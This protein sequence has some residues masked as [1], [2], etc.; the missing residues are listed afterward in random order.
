MYVK[1]LLTGLACLAYIQFVTPVPHVAALTEEAPPDVLVPVADEGVEHSQQV[2]TVMT[3]TQ[4]NAVPANDMVTPSQETTAEQFQ[5]SQPIPSVQTVTKSTADQAPSLSV[6][7]PLPAPEGP[8]YVSMFEF[9]QTKGFRFVEIWNTSSEHVKLDNI[10]ITLEYYDTDSSDDALPYVCQLPLTGYIAPKSHVTYAQPELVTRSNGAYPLHDCISSGRVLVDAT[11]TVSVLGQLNGIDE[12][13]LIPAVSFAEGDRYIRKTTAKTG[14]LTADFT[15]KS[16]T[17]TIAGE[18]PRTSQVYLPPS[19]LPLQVTEIFPNPLLCASGDH[20]ARC[21][22]YIKVVNVS[23][24][25]VDLARYRLRNGSPQAK[26]S[27][28]N[29]STLTG[30]V[31]PHDFTII[32]VDAN[33]ESLAINDDAGATWFEDMLGMVTYANTDAPYEKASLAANQGYAWAYDPSDATW[34]WTVPSPDVKETVFLEPGKGSG[35]IVEGST[36]APCPTGQYRAIETNRCRMIAVATSEQAP[37]KDGQ[38]RSEQTNRCR[39]VATSSD[40]L[41][42]CKEGQYRS[43]ET[44]RCR[45][46]TTAASNLQPCSEDQYRSPETNRCR[47]IASTATNLQPCRDGQERNPETNRCRKMAETVMPDAAFAVRPQVRPMQNHGKW[48]A[49][50]GILTV[51]TAYGAW[52]F[53]HEI[54]S[55]FRKIPYVQ[56][57]KQ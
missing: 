4:P 38:Y 10:L 47:K 34:K 22:S 37:C 57:S 48:W 3:R 53:R 44:N 39:S 15:R 13:L 54:V 24:R 33:G 7:Q 32:T 35:A 11:L 12:K 18:Q 31:L 40:T 43:E 42:V 50:G 26:S 49:L 30:T 14:D 21:Y 41:Q 55:L 19:D 56:R 45:S 28:Y 6:R 2:T 20:D 16:A 52:Q 8:V 46:I 51:A 27:T 29:T 23:D 25:H 5:K 1:V 17:T 9:H 36:L